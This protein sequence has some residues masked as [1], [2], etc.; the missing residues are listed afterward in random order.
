[1]PVARGI[2]ELAVVVAGSDA[3]GKV[4]ELFPPIVGGV[5]IRRPEIKCFA[6]VSRPLRIAFEAGV[7][8]ELRRL[9][10]GDV[11]PGEGRIGAALGGQI[12]VA[13]WARVGH[14]RR[15]GAKRRHA[16][17]ATIVGI[18]VVHNRR[19][20]GDGSGDVAHADQRIGAGALQRRVRREAGRVPAPLGKHRVGVVGRID[21]AAQIAFAIPQIGFVVHRAGKVQHDRHIARTVRRGGGRLDIERAQF[22]DLAERAADGRAAGRLGQV[23][24]VRRHRRNLRREGLRTAVVVISAVLGSEPTGGR[25][26]VEG[27]VVHGRHL[28][29]RGRGGRGAARGAAGEIARAGQRRCVDRILNASLVE[30]QN[31]HIDA[32]RHETEQHDQR[33]GDQRQHGAATA[34][35]A[36]LH[37]SSSDVRRP[38]GS[39]RFASHHGDGR[40]R[41]RTGNSAQCGQ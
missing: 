3:V 37:N 8:I 35:F 41:E 21:H 9:T 17:S 19:H 14:A 13:A 27:R 26:V 33:H 4:E 40:H 31:A 2:I 20:A 29:F 12:A 23:V 32:H 18:K 38:Y 15:S 36:I 24:I 30:R 39:I 10:T 5:W 1:M 7:A 11:E 28:G 22:E 34:V 25:Q 6:P 16:A